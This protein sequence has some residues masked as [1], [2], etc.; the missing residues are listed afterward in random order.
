M[1]LSLPRE[2]RR[3]RRTKWALRFPSSPMTYKA[4]LGQVI[5]ELESPAAGEDERYVQNAMFNPASS[6]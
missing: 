2:E 3:D 4:T 5:K 1:P 6:Q